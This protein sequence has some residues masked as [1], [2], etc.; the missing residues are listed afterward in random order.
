ME[1]LQRR[2]LLGG[3]IGLLV[4][5]I[6]FGLFLYRPKILRS[7][8][9]NS[10]VVNLR[11]QVKD[12]EAMA[13]DIGKLRAQVVSLEDAQRAFMAKVAPRSDI[14]SIV[15]QLITLAEPYHIV[16]TVIQPPGIDTLMR[17]DS[18]DRPLQPIPFVITIQGRYLDIAK[19]IES[20]SEFPY[21]LRTPEIEIITK[22]ELRPLLEVRILINIYVSS[23][24]SSSNL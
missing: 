14:L 5:V 4:I 2:V 17:S 15:Q 18:P 1:L 22:D 13:R 9:V 8:I 7:R 3:L 16:F 12:N 21:F 10:E 19:Y 24:I 23:L 11:K 20:L 6:I